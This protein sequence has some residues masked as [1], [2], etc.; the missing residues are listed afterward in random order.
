MPPGSTV[1]ILTV[2]GR[3]WVY[4][5]NLPQGFSTLTEGGL[6]PK[7]ISSLMR[8][9]FK[10][11]AISFHQSDINYSSTVGHRCCGTERGI[12]AF[13]QSFPAPGVAT[14]STV[15]VVGLAGFNGT[16]ELVWASGRQRSPPE[17]SSSR[18][19][20]DN[21]PGEALDHLR[22]VGDAGHINL[23]V[24]S[25]GLDQ[26]L[27]AF[28]DLFGRADHEPLGVLIVAHAASGEGRCALGVFT[29]FE[30]VHVD[31]VGARD[32]LVVAP[33]VVAVPAEHAELVA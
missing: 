10:P 31:G 15:L 11:M 12:W 3:L 8:G 29:L 22:L 30:E 26:R 25:A 21:L 33:E 18:E 4:C 7:Y 6:S 16:V 23:E 27:Q 20:G 28:G 2:L 13:A 9:Q 1:M 17:P 24:V 19:V 5:S 32:L 14:F